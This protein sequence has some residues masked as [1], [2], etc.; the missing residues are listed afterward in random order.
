MQPFFVFN[1]IITINESKLMSIRKVLVTVI[2]SVAFSASASDKNNTFAVKGVGIT[3]CS[4]FVKS[5]QSKDDLYYV[6]GG[7]LEGYIT[8]FNSRMPETFDLAPWQSTKLLIKAVES[9]CI[10]NPSLQYHQV[11]AELIGNLSRQRIAEGGDYVS[12]DPEGKYVFQAEMVS[13]I[14][15]ALT[16]KDLFNGVINSEVNDAVRE[17]IKAFQNQQGRAATGMPDQATL[18]LL[19]QPQK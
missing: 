14:K 17:S 1:G 11:M 9:V 3:S 8:A 19:F 15:S 6:Y 16:S 13:R 18:F 4:Q 12:F 10:K 7:W 5:A 2:A